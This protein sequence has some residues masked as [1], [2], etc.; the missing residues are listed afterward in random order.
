MTEQERIDELETRFPF[1]ENT[2]V[3]PNDENL[4]PTGKKHNP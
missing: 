2:Q 3:D 4:Q 1:Q